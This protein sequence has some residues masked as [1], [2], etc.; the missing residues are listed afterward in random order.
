MRHRVEK[1]QCGVRETEERI[2]NT[3]INKIMKNHI[4]NIRQSIKRKLQETSSDT[5]GES[6]R[7]NEERNDT[8]M[9]DE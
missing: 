9:N 3:R 5:G 2:T 1:E 7:E 6:E 8:D 4:N